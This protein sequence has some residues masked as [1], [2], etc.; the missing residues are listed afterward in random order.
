MLA[1]PIWIFLIVDAVYSLKK[2]ES[3]WRIKTRLIISIIGFLADFA[4]VIFRPFG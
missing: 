3:N 4:F 2:G 1:L